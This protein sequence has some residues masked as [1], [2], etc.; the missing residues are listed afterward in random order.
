MAGPLQIRENYSL[1]N[2][3]IMQDRMIVVK[4]NCLNM[5]LNICAHTHQTQGTNIN[6]VSD[7]ILFDGEIFSTTYL[8]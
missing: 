2:S 5:M 7:I 8:C 6:T 4:N 3:V 1:E